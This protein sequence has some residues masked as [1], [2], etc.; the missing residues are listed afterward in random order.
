[1]EKKPTVYTSPYEL[2]GRIPLRTAIPLGLQHVLAMFVGN[3]SP[4]LAIMGICGI[5]IDGGH[6]ALRISLLQ[7]AMLVAGLVT[8]LQLYPL[9]PIGGRL[10][11]VMGTSSGFIGINNGIATSMIAG[12]AAGTITSSV[13]A[14]IYAY[15]AVLGASLIGG[16]FEGLLGFAIK[17]LR[18]FFPPVVTGTVVTAIGLSLFGVGIGFFGGGNSAL[19]YGSMWNLLLGLIT[20][21]AIIFFKHAFKGFP[22][23]ASIL[24]GII[25]GYVASFIMGLV[26]PNTVELTNAAGET[27]SVVPAYI[28]K[29]SQVKDAAWFAIPNILPVPLQFNVGAIL[30]MLIMFVVTAVETVG[31]TAGVVKGGLNRDATDKEL[32]GAVVCDG[33]GSS[34]AAVFGVLPNTSFSQN[35]GLVGMTKVVNRFAILMG[36]LILVISGLFPKVGAIISIMPQ[37]VLGGAA[38]MMFASIVV[39][40]INLLTEEPLDGRNATIVAVALGLGYGLGSTA[41]VQSFMPQ[42]LKYIF[43]GSGIVPAALLAIILNICLPKHMEEAKKA[44]DNTSK[45]KLKR[46]KNG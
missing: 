9:G 23:V 3:L 30:P 14:G 37:P 41:A 16:L 26:L 7:N 29:W 13:E 28:T 22:S 32:S 27:V 36:A 19:D 6:A 46:R 8:I 17:P 18:K 24:L 21:L 39:S 42:W 11:I 33:V 25:V 1:M 31:D 40:G 12:I 43:G 2:D 45:K 38:V 34:I 5:T 35:V 44:R 10:P 4:L 15:G 20:L